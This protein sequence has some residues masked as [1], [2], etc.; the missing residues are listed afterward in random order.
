MSSIT[1][2][3][4]RVVTGLW[5]LIKEEMTG[6]MSGNNKRKDFLSGQRSCSPFTLVV[7][8]SVSSLSPLEKL[9]ERP[10]HYDDE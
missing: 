9:S 6:E 5:E 8:F 10:I 1:P 4:C 7:S 3:L 2:E